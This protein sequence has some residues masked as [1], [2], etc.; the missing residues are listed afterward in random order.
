MFVRRGGPFEPARSGGRSNQRV[1]AA[2]FDASFDQCGNQTASFRGLP[3]RIDGR[4]CGNQTASFRGL[5][6][7]IDGRRA[8]EPARSGGE[9]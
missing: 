1:A 9:F 6:R 8:F 7:R 5:P 3:R 2:S 4:S